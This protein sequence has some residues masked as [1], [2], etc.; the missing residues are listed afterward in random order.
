LA[1]LV[2]AQ[3]IERFGFDAAIVFSDILVPAIAMGAEIAFDPGPV[4]AR[5]IDSAAAVAA[6]R[7]VDAEEALGFVADAVRLLVE[8]LGA[9]TPVI[10]FAGAPFTV[11]AYLVEGAG[12]RGFERTKSLLFREPE[13]FRALLE[14]IAAVTAS[15]LAAQRRAGASALMLFDTHAAILS[16]ADYEAFA[17]PYAERVL[18]A[19]GAEAPRIYFAPGAPALLPRIARLGAEVVGVDFRIGLGDARRAAGDGVAVQGNLDPAVLL[20]PRPTVVERTHA[21]LEENA[22]R[23]GHIANLGHGILPST[24]IE[25]VEA[26][27]AAVRDGGAR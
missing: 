25:N 1:A 21:M 8:R 23:P 12:S 11:A 17:A 2:S 9:R 13:T 24:P 26:F 19:L 5:P 20:A 14:K 22:G 10:G 3:P 4:V 15:H 27:V 7:A 6:L 18:G 16:P